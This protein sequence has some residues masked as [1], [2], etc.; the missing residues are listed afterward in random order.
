MTLPHE[1][2]ESRLNAFDP[3]IRAE[4]LDD[5]LAGATLALPTETANLHCHTFYSFNAYGH[6]PTSL[7]WLAQ[8]Q[9]MKLIGMVDF[10]VLDAV[11][12]FLAA[13][14]RAGVRGTAGIETRVY[15][16]EF[17]VHEIN[18]PGEPG[19]LYHMGVGFVSSSV[20]DDVAPIL[21][22]LR[23]RAEQRNRQMVERVNAYLAP[24]MIDYDA[25]VLPL[26]PSGNATERH[27][28]MAYISAANRQVDDPV[29]FWANRLG[30]TVE[31]LASL[32]QDAPKLQNSVRSK[33]MK[34]GGVGY[35]QPDAGSFPSLADFHTLITACGALPCAAWL[36]GTTSGE[37]QIGALLEL[38]I[39]RGVVAFNIVPDRNWNIADSAQ[40]QL[41][42]KNLYQVVQLAGEL[43][44]PLNIGTEMN[45]YGQRLVDDFDA[46]ELEPL[47][48]SFMDGAYTI[49]GHTALARWA[50]L[51][52]QSAWA[53]AH[54]PT[55][56]ARNAFYR[57]VGRALEP[58]SSGARLPFD[59]GWTPGDI[60]SRLSVKPF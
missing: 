4:A 19:V 5:L 48:D 13:C 17:A 10:D 36:D 42:M 30:M 3:A 18:S 29:T 27:M 22:D 31:Q 44:L 1:H 37:Q 56:R 26:T 46:P 60:L 39:E 43:D 24:V 35:V 25:D 28:V 52:Y 32:M 6:S 12:E 38:L 34:Q 50:G 11:D 23:A 55:R 57:Q 49:Y 20:P 15:L 14:D 16:P 40:K 8:R 45:S 2:A 7:A 41:K 59:D 51:G 33:L 47:R 53:Q 58:G 21:T 54:L 9:R